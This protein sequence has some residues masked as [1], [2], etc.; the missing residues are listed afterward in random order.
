MLR[1]S[2]VAATVLSAL[3]VASPAAARPTEGIWARVP[4]AKKVK[5]APKAEEQLQTSSAPASATTTTA[6]N[7]TS[8]AGGTQGK[9]TNCTADRPC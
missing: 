2:L 5:K 7:G 1:K 6:S 4:K 3:L 8:T 9:P